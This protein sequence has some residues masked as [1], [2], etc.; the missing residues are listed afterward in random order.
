LLEKLDLKPQEC[1]FIDDDEQNVHAANTLGINGIQF[2]SVQ[3]L[4]CDLMPFFAFD[5]F[6]KKIKN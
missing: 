4:V 5:L 2:Q 1:L 3:K 6:P